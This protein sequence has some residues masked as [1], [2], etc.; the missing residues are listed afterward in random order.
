MATKINVQSKLQN[1]DIKYKNKHNFETISDVTFKILFYLFGIS[2]YPSTTERFSRKP[3][4]L[5][6]SLTVNITIITMIGIFYTK[7]LLSDRDIVKSLFDLILIII[8]LITSISFIYVNITKDKI[9]N[10]LNETLETIS[11]EIDLR[12]TTIKSKAIYLTLFITFLYKFIYY[13]VDS[14]IDENFNIF[15]IFVQDYGVVVA[16]LSFIK[17]STALVKIERNFAAVNEH[18]SNLDSQTFLLKEFNFKYINHKVYLFQRYV[19]YENILS[20]LI[21]I[22][23]DNFGY[24]LLVDT[25]SL[26]YRIFLDL[27]RSF[28]IAE[29][30]V[31]DKNF[32]LITCL[33]TVIKF[34]RIIV[35]VYICS[36]IDKQVS[37]IIMLF[38]NEL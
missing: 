4:S 28:V 12:K 30:I 31:L 16:N 14:V 9:Y 18:F 25:T 24:I 29:S 38:L 2:L 37:I 1:S 7:M 35:F 22:I 3:I 27:L 21:D 6:Y 33:R 19:K 11:N 13:I 26:V 34:G 10:E 17:I 23:N 20:N 5:I 32:L 36:Q 15:D 8:N